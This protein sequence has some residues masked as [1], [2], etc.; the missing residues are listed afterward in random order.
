MT[1]KEFEK[2]YRLEDII[3]EGKV[4][5]HRAL[6][7]S[8]SPVFV[9]FLVQDEAGSRSSL[10]NYLPRLDTTHAEKIRV[11]TEVDG[12]A[13]MVTDPLEEFTSLQDWL[14]A[15]AGGKAVRDPGVYTRLLGNLGE[16]KSLGETVVLGV[17]GEAE[18]E[19][20]EEDDSE[21]LVPPP[22]A[23]TR[24]VQPAEP[25]GEAEVEPEPRSELAPQSAEPEQEPTEPEQDPTEPEQ[26]AADASIMETRV[27]DAEEIGRLS[28]DRVRVTPPASEP[29]SS[30][31]PPPKSSPPPSPKK[32]GRPGA[33]TM[34]FGE[35]HGLRAAS[36]EDMPALA[37]TRITPT[38]ESTKGPPRPVEEKA[39]SLPDIP[40]F[41]E[42][43]VTP[44]SG[45]KVVFPPRERAGAEP[46]TPPPPDHEP[47]PPSPEQ[48]PPSVPARQTSP[49]AGKVARGGSSMSPVLIWTLVV[50]ALVIGVA[51]GVFLLG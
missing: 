7:L 3:A 42:T 12:V 10:L 46:V 8:G 49:A 28:G 30:P 50:L 14:E 36:P 9:H 34:V 22:A 48:Q 32:T 19:G 27:L 20:P 26:E 23:E 6:D 24:L 1:G 39:P 18:E 40:E 45:N 43:R 5:S 11:L 37:E 15:A 44:I 38:S 13:V 17:S 33:F 16:T 2:E 47:P 51:A 35:D 31:P 21:P 4:V 41:A 25:E 29:P